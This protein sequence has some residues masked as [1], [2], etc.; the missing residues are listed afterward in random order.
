MTAFDCIQ[1]HRVKGRLGNRTVF[2]LPV[3]SASKPGARI[4]QSICQRARTNEVAR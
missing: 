3:D 2:F 1:L 4:A